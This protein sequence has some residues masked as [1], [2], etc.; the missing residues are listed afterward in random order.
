MQDRIREVL[1]AHGRMAVD[2]REVDDQA[3]LY[4]LGLTSHA[5]VDVMLALEDA[6]GVEFPDEVLKKS[7]FA[8]IRSIEQVLEGLVTSSA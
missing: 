8:S 6:F 5:S 2:P 4:K 3:D 1:A 7:T